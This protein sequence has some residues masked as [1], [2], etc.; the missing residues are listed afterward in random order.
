MKKS[1]VPTSPKISDEVKETTCY[2]CACRC[3]IRVHLE[4]GKLRYIEGNSKHPVNQGVLC[5]KGASGIM[6]QHSPAKLRKPLKRVGERGEGNFVEIEWDEALNIASSWLSKIRM[7]D[8][9]K[10][11]F[12]TGRDQSQALTSWWAE[13]FGTPNY[14]AHG[15]FCSVNMAAAGLYTVG[16][17]FWEFGE[18]DWDRTKY[19]LMFG[20]A[21]DHSSNPIKIGLSK[22]KNRNAKFVSVN[23]VRTGYSAIA[24]EWIGIKPGTDGLFIISII[25]ELL[26]ADKIDFEFVSR[27]TNAPWLV[28]QNPGSEDDG[29]FARG[30][31]GEPLFWNKTTGTFE[32]INH[33]NSFDPALLGSYKLDNGQLVK[34]VFAL[35][36]ERYLD[37]KYKP[38]IVEKITGIPAKT[39]KRIA[40]EIATVAFEQQIVIEEPWTDWL[41]KKHSQ[42][43]G[44]PVSIHAMRGISAHSNGFQT[45]RALH[46]LQIFLGSVDCPGGWRYRSPYPKQT[47]PSILPSID[48]GVNS[49]LN[50]P[51]LGFPLGPENLLLD[52]KGNPIRI[53]KA[54]SWEAPLSIHGMMH[55]VISNAW[56]GDPYKIDTLFMYMANMSWN[57]SMNTTQTMR[58]LT[59][60]D[61]DTGEYKIPRIIYSDA[62]WSEMVAYSDLVLPDTTYLERWDCISL[63]D[64]PISNAE[65]PADGIRQ[66]VLDIDRDVR[67]FQDVLLDLGA[68]LSLPGMIN[69]KGMPK[70]P[71]GLKDYMINHER[72]PKIGMLSGWRGKGDRHGIGEVNSDQINRYIENGCFWLGKIPNEAKFFR[73]VNS[74]YSSYAVSMGFLENEQPIFHQLYLETMQKFRLAAEGFGKIKPPKNI[75]ERL[76]FHFDPIPFWHEV[77]EDSNVENSEYPFRIITQRPMAMYHSWDSQNIWQRQILNKNKLYINTNSANRIGIVDGDWVQVISSYGKIRCQVQLM[78]GVEPNTVWTWNGIGKRG[79][80][81]GLKENAP[82]V[83]SSFLVNHLVPDK[84]FEGQKN[85]NFSYSDPITGQAA[86]YDVR[87][88]I[89]K[90]NKKDSM[91]SEPQFPIINFF[92]T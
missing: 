44:R 33:S 74:K 90:D 23:P 85:A 24:D 48:E 80:V 35:L 61:Q 27:Y 87:V 20:V 69:E 18:P 83:E 49:S 71:E 42:T 22:L 19:F 5:A 58:M 89:E 65:G 79:G 41:G 92:K 16:G 36:S 4:K 91:M 78:S 31:N 12:F 66:P 76:K 25:R 7:Q 56:A 38:A 88:R 15:G 6:K 62:F 14:S 45:C 43:I 57:S 46:I 1:N 73:N 50:G 34:P 11:A 40:K 82:E 72:K 60:K 64:R 17:S 67:P 26:M 53:D 30:V 68:K 86:W 75:E 13:K 28:I 51:P 77:S 47:P 2:M 9:K 81:W 32:E 10:L 52:T 63:L 70:Y 84:Y 21:E 39:I 29:L 3:G 37:D 59:D 54:F 55:M 8:P